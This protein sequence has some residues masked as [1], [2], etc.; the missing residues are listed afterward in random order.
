MNPLKKY[1]ITVGDAVYADVMKQPADLRERYLQM[2]LEQLDPTLYPLVKR[3]GDLRSAL[4]AAMSTHLVQVFK[5]AGQG[6][7]APLREL[8]STSVE[9]TS[10]LGDVGDIL[11]DIFNFAKTT[12]GQLAC[13]GNLPAAV[14][15]VGGKD[16]A[17]G[18]QIA[19]TI[20]CNN[21]QMTPEQ[22]ALLVQQQV[23]AQQAQR[24]Q[25]L[26]MYALLAG[27]ALVVYMLIKKKHE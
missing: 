26:F 14:N 2:L 10:A 3:S 8:L 11:G 18:A 6:D 20:L 12:V 24:D 23:A 16:A 19:T 21:Q 4:R 22:Y 17:A 7:T 15:D 25:Q 9:D 13:T 27:G 5:R 1:G